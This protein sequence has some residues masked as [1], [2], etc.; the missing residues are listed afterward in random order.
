MSECQ[1]LHG[2]RCRSHEPKQTDC[3]SYTAMCACVCCNGE[4]VKEQ[5]QGEA[6]VSVCV[7]VCYSMENVKTEPVVAT[8]SLALESRQCCNVENVKERH[9]GET[10]RQSVLCE[11]N[12]LNH[13]WMLD[14]VCVGDRIERSKR[15]ATRS[16]CDSVCV[17]TN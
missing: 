6:D 12:I 9:Q 10:E 3:R 4:N 2:K 14:T 16:G 8:R 17:V 7:C 11:R 5:H 15:T 1:H 13:C